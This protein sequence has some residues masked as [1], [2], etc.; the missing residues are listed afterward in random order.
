MKNKRKQVKAKVIS[1]KEYLLLFLATIVVCGGYSGILLAAVKKNNA[2]SPSQASLLMLGYVVFVSVTICIIVAAFQYFRLN[3]PIRRLQDSAQRITNGDFSVRLKPYL[4]T[5]KKNE[6]E[7]LYEDFNKMAEEL[8]TTETL[9]T[10]FISSVSHEIKTPIA[11]IENYASFLQSKNIDEKERSKYIKTIIQG[12]RRLSELVNDILNMNKLEHLKIIPKEK[13]YSLDEQIRRC[14]IFSENL[15]SD[16]KITIS[17]DLND[18][19]ISYDESLLE[20]VWNNLISNAVKYTDAGGEINI[21]LKK[22]EGYA[23]VSIRD[24]GCGMDEKT[25]HH[26]F[27]KFYQGDTSRSRE[28]NGLGLSMV[29][30][31]ISI[32]D[33]EISVD[34]QLGIGSSFTIKLK[35]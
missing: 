2:S 3:R 16:K 12:A 7:I 29:K 35:I 11:I 13:P 5:N 17:A 18:V 30:K 21:L 20:L 23:I 34:S 22:E 32:L 14:V 28:G 1:T 26:I 4:G 9:K 25:L 27:D 15:W 8:S 31:I 10:D 6:I 33:G 19:T 24:N